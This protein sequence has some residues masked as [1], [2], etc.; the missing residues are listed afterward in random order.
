MDMPIGM[1]PRPQ[2]GRKR[3][4]WL[5]VPLLLLAVLA[6][7]GWYWYQSLP[8][9]ERV[10][11]FDGQT[12]VILYQGE[13]SEQSYLLEQG[14]IL[15]PFDFIQKYLDPHL[16]WDEPTRSVIV[17]TSDKVL[18]MVSGQATAFLNQHPVQL[19]VPVKEQDDK[20]Y[21][22]V[23][24]LTSLYPV[25][26][27]HVEQSGVLIIE[28]AG[29]AVQQG[30]VTADEE[31]ASGPVPLR[32]TASVKAPIV[33]EVNS[34]SLVDVLREEAGWYLVQSETGMQGF[35]PEDAVELKQVRTTNPVAAKPAKQRTAWKPL[36]QKVNLV[37][38]HVVNRNPDVSKLPAMPGLQ[39]VSPTWFELRDEKGTLT[40]KA[41]PAYVKWA[42]ARGYQVWGLVSNGFNPDWTT[43]VLRD[44]RLRSN[45]IAQILHYARLYDLDGINLDFENVYVEDKERLVQFVRELTPYLHEQGLTV[46]MDVTIKSTSDRW[47]RFYD[48]A[49]LA[50]VVDYIAVM[51]YDE[52]WAS[53]PVAGSVA[54]LPWTEAGLKGVLEEVPSEKLLL[55]IPFYTRLWK[56]TPQADGSVKVTSKALSMQAAWDWVNE[57]KLKP[58]LDQKSG[59]LF[60]S[61]RDPAEGATYKIWLEEEGSITRRIA[62]VHKYN[63]AGIASWRRG[64]EQPVIW[65]TIE[66]HLQQ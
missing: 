26:V 40:N 50:K 17:T 39:V 28:A 19:Q 53:S 15:L 66:Q 18:Q 13:A 45:M 58:E 21:V 12:N 60:V 4:G 44:Y 55:G 54:S 37:W 16:Y 38:E 6:G 56:E 10:S 46:S 48:R 57:R 47:S 36:G 14:E 2:R 31:K 62:L 24:P 61:Y 1:T 27:R 52:H 3:N 29:Y 22:P 8:S 41:D 35:L 5:L 30:M 7:A 59:Q 32:K 23:S 33:A 64:F 9:T 11:P 63:L 25:Q 49:A 20:R 51:T 42:H 65:T 34:G 43:A